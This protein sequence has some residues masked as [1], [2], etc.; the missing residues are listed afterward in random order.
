MTPA[1]RDARLEGAR[2]AQV[3]VPWLME[4]VFR[5]HTLIA[6]FKPRLMGAALE[7][8]VPVAEPEP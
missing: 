3:L 1:W 6:E 8:R 2:K 5:A 7:V 4:A